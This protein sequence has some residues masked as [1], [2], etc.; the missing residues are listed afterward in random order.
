MF[1]GKSCLSFLIL[2]AHI[3]LKSKSEKLCFRSEFNLKALECENLELKY[4]VAKEK[5][6]KLQE[7]LEEKT[8]IL[9]K[10]NSGGISDRCC[11][12]EL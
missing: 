11:Q 6:E 12:F 8:Q 9:T 10:L 2:T 3:L 7:E 5:I 4:S 1:Q